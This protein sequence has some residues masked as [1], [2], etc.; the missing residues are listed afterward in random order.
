MASSSTASGAT[1]AKSTSGAA[2]HGVWASHLYW[3]LILTSSWIWLCSCR[4]HNMSVEICFTFIDGA[5]GEEAM[6][7][8]TVLTVLDLDTGKQNSPIESISVEAF[9]EYLASGNG[10]YV[11]QDTEVAVTVQDM[12]WTFT[13]TTNGNADDNPTGWRGHPERGIEWSF[14]LGLSFY[15]LAGQAR[16]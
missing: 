2:L 15:H 8:E 7:D 6:I 11:S 9:D 3:Y 13:G 4:R 1:L 14:A 10:V 16:I 5:T 12:M